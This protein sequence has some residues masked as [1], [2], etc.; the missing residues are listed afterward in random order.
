MDVIHTLIDIYM[1]LCMKI[2]LL[3]NVHPNLLY[4]HLLT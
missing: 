1:Q 4:S 3:T 2:T